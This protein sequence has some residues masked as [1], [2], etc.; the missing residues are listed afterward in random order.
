M[1]SPRKRRLKRAIRRER[2]DVITGRNV[3]PDIDIL[4]EAQVRKQEN[5][6]AEKGIEFDVI[7][8]AEPETGVE[9]EVLI[10]EEP[11]IE[12]KVE[13]V[14]KKGKKSKTEVE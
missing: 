2:L 10:G 9:V 7:V 14:V 4:T 1:G 13:K 3:L 6:D 8:G 12:Q 11:V 5:E